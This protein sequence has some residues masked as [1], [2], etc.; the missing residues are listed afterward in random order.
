MAELGAWLTNQDTFVCEQ[1]P[2]TAVERQG[3]LI[4]IETEPGHQVL[5]RHLGARPE[6]PLTMGSGQS[7]DPQVVLER[8]A[9]HRRLCG[10]TCFRRS[11]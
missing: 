1:S 2:V 5:C 8:P 10:G 4:R 11:K 7:D 6:T 3:D 9:I